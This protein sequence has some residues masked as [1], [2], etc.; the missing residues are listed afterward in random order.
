MLSFSTILHSVYLRQ[1]YLPESHLKF[2]TFEKKS[3]IHLYTCIFYTYSIT[4]IHLLNI[5]HLGILLLINCKEQS[6]KS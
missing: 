6:N 1:E 4:E 2:N 3:Y 5:S